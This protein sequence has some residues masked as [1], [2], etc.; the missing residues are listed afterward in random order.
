MTNIIASDILKGKQKNL[1]R[2]CLKK[3]DYMNNLC[4]G[5]NSLLLRIRIIVSQ[6]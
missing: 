5:D 3:L 2:Q 6:Y 1:N 4:S